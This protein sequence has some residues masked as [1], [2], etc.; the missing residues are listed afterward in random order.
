[1]RI[2]KTNTIQN[3]TIKIVPLAYLELGHPRGG[4]I[5]EVYRVASEPLVVI[6]QTTNPPET[7]WILFGPH[8]REKHGFTSNEIIDTYLDRVLGEHQRE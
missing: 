2:P 6:D 7:R 1:M 8:G 4:E 3:G 5:E